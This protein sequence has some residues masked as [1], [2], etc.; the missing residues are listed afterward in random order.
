M[1]KHRLGKFTLVWFAVTAFALTVCSS[2]AFGQATT[3]SV[4]GT[5]LD[6]NQAAV[7]DAAVKLTN[8]ETGAER[9]TTTNTEGYFTFPRLPLGTYTVR[10]TKQG[11]RTYEAKSVLVALAQDTSLRVSLEVGAVSE[12]VLVEGGA[13]VVEPTTAQ[14]TSTFDNKKIAQLPAF[15]GRLDAIALL[16]P[17]VIPG[18]GNVNSNG[19]TLSVNGQRSRSNNFTI[20]GQDNNDNSIGGPGLFLSNIDVVQEFSIITNNFSAEYGRNQGAIVNIVTKSGTNNVHGALYG[21]HQ[22][23][24]FF[25]NSFDNNRDGIV[26]PR[27]NDNIDGG[28]I[29]G[30]FRRDKDFFFFNLQ[31]EQ[32]RSISTN[33]SGASSFVITPTGLATLISRCGVTNTLAAYRDHGPFAQSIGNPTVLPGSAST[34]RSQSQYAP[35][36]SVTLPNGTVINDPCG[37]S[38]FSFE[39]ARITRNTST[40]FNQYDFGMKYDFTLSRKDNVHARYLFQDGTSKNANGSSSGYEIDVPF[41]SQNLGVTW[42]RQLTSRQFNELRFNYGRL[43]VAFEGANTFPISQINNNIARFSMPSGF[44]NFGLATN[45]P[46]NRFVNTYQ[47]VDNWSI[48]WGRHTLKT[49]VDARRQLTPVAFLPQI[50]GQFNFNRISAFIRN[51]PALEQAPPLTDR[52]G[53]LNASAGD[54]TLNIRETDAFVYFQDDF[55]IKP[56]FTLNLGVRYEYTGQPLNVVHEVSLKRE[57]DPSTALWL[58]SLP[59]EDRTVPEILPDKNNWAPRIGFAYTPRWGKRL[60]GQ[61]KTVFRGGFSMA[62]DPSFFNLLLNVSTSAPNVFLYRLTGITVPPDVTGAGVKATF[63]PPL[64]TADPRR[65][66]QTQFA[67]PFLSPYAENWTFGIQRQ[68]TSKAAFEVRYAGSRGVKLFQSINANPLVSAFVNN[69]F[70]SVVPP[71]ITPG[72][73]SGR[74]DDNFRL[75]RVR[76]NFAA[77]TY[78]GLQSE[79]RGQLFNQLTTTLAYTYSHN[80]DNVSEVFTFLGSGSVAFAQNP[81]DVNKGE[82]G[83]SNI[84]LRHSVAWSF[85]WDI[86]AF[87]SQHGVIG[88][89]LGG[90]TASGVYAWRTGRPMTPVCFFCSSPVNDFGF[91]NTFIGTFDTTRP[92]VSNPNAPLTSAGVFAGDACGIGLLTTAQCTPPTPTV[93]NPAFIPSTTLLSFNDLNTTGAATVVTPSDVAF[94]ANGLVAAQQFGT[95]FGVGRN[96]F[97]GPHFNRADFAMF[98]NAKISERFSVQLRWE[99]RNIF[100]TPFLGIPDLFIDDAGSTFMDSAANASGVFPRQMTV[101]IRFLF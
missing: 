1:N 100:N 49:G 59:I 31:S 76:G 28:A 8:V 58:Q 40:P 41:R 3:G 67:S 66:N 91:N 39:T 14:T 63:A 78:H 52:R 85:I 29:G 65:A 99:A 17:G 34:T 72:P 56:N 23:A 70:G 46:Q 64:N 32:S 82:R 89:I 61:E 6:P 16:S 36:P 22:N 18:F 38:S 54:L 98:K 9:E 60:F 73:V 50:N 2:M 81:F 24:A 57:S 69:G 68:L 53:S 55:K 21:F 26:K 19:A 35:R 83:S 77:S 62:Y 94:I 95:P 13:P 15:G 97:L 25:A 10:V 71:G 75:V 30:P 48:Q 12:T 90:W 37:T 86:P 27:F 45:L 92:F 7:A 79:F 47:W 80:L 96:T 33:T 11:F 93:P 20:D 101:G 87:K 84:D 44:L 88:H 43:A 51:I 4:S 74:A 42:T 5:V